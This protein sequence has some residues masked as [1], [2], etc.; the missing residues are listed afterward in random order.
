MGMQK[1]A[2]IAL[3]GGST[4]L[5]IGKRQLA[6]F[7]VHMPRDE[8]EQSAIGQTLAD[9]DTELGALETR[10]EKA[11]QI[12]QGMMQELLTGRIRLPVDRGRATE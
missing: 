10:L 4:F 7:E 2:L 11:R 5:E 1:Q 9:M 6:S 12:K 3:C 8:A